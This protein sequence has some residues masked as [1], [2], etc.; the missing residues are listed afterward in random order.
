MDGLNQQST[1]VKVESFQPRGGNQEAR[2]PCILRLQLL[3]KE[4]SKTAAAIEGALAWAEEPSLTT[5]PSLSLPDAAPGV[6]AGCSA[7]EQAGAKDG[8]GAAGL[9]PR[10]RLNPD[11]FQANLVSSHLISYPL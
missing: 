4:L 11:L 3:Q 5:L 2:R 10:C 6:L 9:P 1:V 8:Q 7:I